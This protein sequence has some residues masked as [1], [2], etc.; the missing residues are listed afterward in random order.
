[1]IDLSVVIITYN[2]KKLLVP[3]IRS[4]RRSISSVSHE[5]I[6]VENGSKDGSL[7]WLRSRDDIITIE[8]E[9]NRGIAPARNQGMERASGRYLLILDVDTRVEPGAFEALVHCM[10]RNPG[11]GIGAPKMT[12]GSGQLLYTCR[13][14]PTV[15][16]KIFR[17]LP[18]SFYDDLIDR[19]L[20]KDWPH[21]TERDV[22]YVIGACQIIRRQAYENIGPLDES[23]FYGPEDIDYCLR[24]WERGWRVRYFPHSVVRHLERHISTRLLSSMTLRHALGLAHFFRKHRYLV[25]TDKLPGAGGGHER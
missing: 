10:D 22:D 8:N 5:I 3:C 15:F 6:V 23:I 4:V 17:R 1:M 14:Y 13:N 11:V 24:A 20:L 7:E 19:E 2:S 9:S 16:T 25:S 18:F 21:D 12:D